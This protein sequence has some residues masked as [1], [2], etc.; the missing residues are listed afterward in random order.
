MKYQHACL[1]RCDYDVYDSES[2]QS[3]VWESNLILIGCY[4]TTSYYYRLYELS[5]YI[6]SREDNCNFWLYRSNRDTNMKFGMWSP[7]FRKNAMAW[8]SWKSGGHFGILS[9]CRFFWKGH[10]RILLGP[11]Y[12]LVSQFERF[13]TCPLYYITKCFLHSLFDDIA[14]GWNTE[15]VS[16]CLS[17]KSVLSYQ[18]Q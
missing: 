6:I 14:H 13:F 3:A 17:N 2:S 16:S 9:G 1:L 10:F 12:M 15:T 4:S 18:L 11:I 7:F 5:E 8:P